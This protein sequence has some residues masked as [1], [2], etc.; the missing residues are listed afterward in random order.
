[1]KLLYDEANAY[2][3][4]ALQF[5]PFEARVFK[6]VLKKPYDLDPHP[7]S[8][9]DSFCLHPHSIP[10]LP[11][12]LRSSHTVAL[13]IHTRGCSC[14]GP[15]PL[16]LPSAWNNRLPFDIHMLT[17]WT[18]SSLCSNLSSLC[19]LNLPITKI[20]PTLTTLFKPS[21]PHVPLRCIVFPPAFY[22]LNHLFSLLS[23]SSY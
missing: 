17:L 22:I 11:Y 4:K 10:G 14:L 3:L 15:L 5:G 19:S 2:L 1:M 12:S 8:G 20:W 13:L 16:T 21:S 6:I 9:L 23:I 18:S 7:L